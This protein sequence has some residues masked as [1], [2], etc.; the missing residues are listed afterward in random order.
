MEYKL[1]CWDDFSIPVPVD[2][3]WLAFDEDGVTFTFGNRP[4]TSFYEWYL[5]HGTVGVFT[6]Q[7]I[8]PPEPG[9]WD[10]QLYWIGD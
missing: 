9:S 7:M 2:H 1:V 8:Q 4:I 10:T 6:L 3:N 5:P